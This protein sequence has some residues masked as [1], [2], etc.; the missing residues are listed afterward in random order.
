MITFHQ[1]H[2]QL[3]QICVTLATCRRQNG[4]QIHLA[5][6]KGLTSPSRMSASIKKKKKKRNN[7]VVVLGD[8]NARV[9]N[10]KLEGVVGKYG[11]PG[12]NLSGESLLNMCVE[13]ELVVGNSLFK[14][15]AINKYT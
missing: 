6:E 7:Y 13:N 8:L 11:V 3:K 1:T 2:S 9:G 12:R 15:R 10:V 14:K 5:L 4:K